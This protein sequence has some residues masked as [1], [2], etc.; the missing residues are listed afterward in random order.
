MNSFNQVIGAFVSK[1]GIQFTDVL[2]IIGVI[3]ITA[4]A[5]LAISYLKIDKKIKL[6]NKE[7]V[8]V[9]PSK[10]GNSN[11]W[12]SAYGFLASIP[13]FKKYVRRITRQYE[14]RYPGDLKKVREQTAKTIC[15]YWSITIVAVVAGLM[16]A[17]TM[18]TR[19]VIIVVA[20][21][22]NSYLVQNRFYSQDATMLRQF[23]EY[24]GDVRHHYFEHEMIDEAIFE[25]LDKA[26][27][28]M[29]LHAEQIYNILIADDMDEAIEK[30]NDVV[31]NNFMKTFVALAVT[32]MQFGDRTVNGQSMFLGTLID[33]KEEINIDLLKRKKID[34]AFSGLVWI[35]VLPILCLDIIKDW[36]IENVP[37]LADFY[38]G[39]QG[40]IIL[41]LLFV[42]TVIIY[43]I[44][45]KLKSN[46]RI[47]ET[48]H[49]FLKKV[50]EL[51]FVKTMLDNYIGTHYGKILEMKDILKKTGEGYSEREFIINR[52]F[53]FAGIVIVMMFLLVNVHIISKSNIITDYTNVENI[54]SGAAEKD[55]ATMKSVIKDFTLK[56]KEYNIDETG[57]DY[58]ALLD[59]ANKVQDSLN[60]SDLENGVVQEEQEGE[61]LTDG[62]IN[63]ATIKSLITDDE[64]LK[65]DALIALSAQEVIAR[66]DKYQNE[67]FHWYELIFVLICGYCGWLYPYIML[68]YRMKLLQKDMEDEVIQY[69]SIIIMLIYIDQMTI[70]HILE[71]MERFAII[72]RPSITMCLNE[73][74]AGDV[75]ALD[76][77][78][79]REPFAPFSRIIENL[80][81]SDRIGI[82]KAFNEISVDRVNYQAK[83]K[84]EN[85][86]DIAN[87]GSIASFLANI[88]M[89]AVVVGYL[90]YPFVMESMNQ[91]TTYMAQINTL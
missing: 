86:M 8:Y 38:N 62:S 3:L 4:L 56:Y 46:I 58:S 33:L 78:I 79:K 52:V 66:I 39:T 89:S 64:R 49:P 48:T 47:V 72:F 1:D 25:S 12:V 87:K 59:S 41:L 13:I 61:I 22:I 24:L 2:L 67:Y 60:I 32:V 88:P 53:Y 15:M 81:M 37:E 75:Q 5:I 23:N 45:M 42:I 76:N 6:A 83:R 10:R 7:V 63:E 85:E 77:L 54:T 90:I 35:C 21:L 69:Q 65:S 55:V 31:P 82:Q 84:Q 74:N 44:I 73:L 9:P 70:D 51:P 17:K 14:I 34:F 40:I 16:N 11:K 20:Y 27:P 91:L 50:T 18:Y 71:W 26:S 36:G 43:N 80:K 19:L 57:A 29:R 28:N 68:K 30:Y